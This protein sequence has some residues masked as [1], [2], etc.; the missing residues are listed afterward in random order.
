SVPVLAS[1]QPTS[2]GA[3][4]DVQLVTKPFNRLL[5]GFVLK[6]QIRRFEDGVL[7]LS[8]KAPSRTT[9]SSSEK[10]ERRLQHEKREMAGLAA[11]KR[12]VKLRLTP[13]GQ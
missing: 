10:E 12:S 13:P 8:K 4:S 6:G 5:H 9:E 7:S 1:L 2:N 11:L 3:E